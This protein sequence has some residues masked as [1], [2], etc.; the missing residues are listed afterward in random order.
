MVALDCSA[1]ESFRGLV[2]RFCA[3]WFTCRPV[4]ALDHS[5]GETV[6]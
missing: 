5:A 4:V 3:E 6:A 2:V 1:E